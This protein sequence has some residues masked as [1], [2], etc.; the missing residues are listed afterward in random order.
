[1]QADVRSQRRRTDEAGRV[2]HQTWERERITEGW[3][4]S[5]QA[6]AGNSPTVV[7][8]LRLPRGD[9]AP[10]GAR[11]SVEASGVCW[12]G[13]QEPRGQAQEGFLSFHAF[14]CDPRWTGRAGQRCTYLWLPGP[15]LSL[16]NAKCMSHPGTKNTSSQENRLARLEMIFY[17]PKMFNW[18]D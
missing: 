2:T 10:R 6:C 4:E 11:T 7:G 15:A 12:E 14:F 17:A 16:R 9:K 5:P 3:R 13:G 1:M 8:L 18:I